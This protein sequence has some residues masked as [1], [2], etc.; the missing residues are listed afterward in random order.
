[1]QLVKKSINVS[2]NDDIKLTVYPKRKNLYELLL[3]SDADN[4]EKAATTQALA[5][6]F[7]TMQPVARNLKTLGLTEDGDTSRDRGENV[8]TMPEIEPQR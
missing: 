3:P 1:M 8:L 6:M 2:E 5:A 7:Q 4:S